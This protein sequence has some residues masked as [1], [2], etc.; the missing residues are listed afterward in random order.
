VVGS[1]YAAALTLFAGPAAP[2]S[3]VPER[4]LNAARIIEDAIR[5]RVFPGAVVVIG[6]SDTVLFASGFGRL[7]WERN[8]S[9]PNPA[10]TLWDL[11]SLTKV[12][13]T[14]SAAM[15]LVDQGKLDLDTPVRRYLP[16]FDG[17]EK[18]RVT[19]RMLLDHTSGLPSWA[20]LYREAQRRAD[21]I[22]SLYAVELRATPG[23]RAEY[24]DLNAMLLGLVVEAVGGS[25]LDQMSTK[26]VFEPLAMRHTTFA[27]AIADPSRVAPSIVRH[28]RAVAGEVNDRNAFALRGIA[29]HAGLFASGLDLARFAQ[30]WLR[31]GSLAGVPWV[32]PATMHTFLQR[33]RG[34]GTR[35]LGWDTPDFSR[36]DHSPFGRLATAT[37]YGHTGWTGTFLWFDPSRD[38]FLVLLTN[39]SL[40]PSTNRSLRA[41]RQVRASLSDAIAEL[42]PTRCRNGL[43]AC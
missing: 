9:R 12:V 32:N 38:L 31:G 30:V 6:R 7:S 18:S 21:A 22:R 17:P 4:W 1:S 37:T 24:S 42:I 35:A 33:S 3:D 10:T 25:S 34:S 27:S 20:P 13:A 29:G 39:R 28:G 43:A 36:L 11:A 16:S 2:K 5:R 41:M 23:L 15:A 8:S 26:A 19:V 14:T 40:N